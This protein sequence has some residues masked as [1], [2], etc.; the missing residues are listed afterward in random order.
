MRLGIY[1]T[2]V[3]VYKYCIV[4]TKHSGYSVLNFQWYHVERRFCGELIYV[5]FEVYTYALVEKLC[6]IAKCDDVL[7]LVNIL[8]Y[9]WVYT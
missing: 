8:C 7:S 6:A 2:C 5:A 4:H 3:S 9:A 1:V